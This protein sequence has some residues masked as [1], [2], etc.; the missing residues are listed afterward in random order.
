MK[1]IQ[2]RYGGCRFRSRLEA[3]WAVAFDA[4]GLRWDYEPQGYVINGRPYLPD[5]YLP[6]A[7]CWVEIKPDRFEPDRELADTLAALA[8]ESRRRVVLLSGID[9]EGCLIWHPFADGCFRRQ[10]LPSAAIEAGRS[11]RFEHGER[12]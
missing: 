8:R 3:R 4:A 11:A 12:G 9:W 10:F 1:A 7:G 6:Q 5:F 2:T